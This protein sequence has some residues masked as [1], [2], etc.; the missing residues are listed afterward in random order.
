MKILYGEIDK[1]KIF[2][3]ITGDA[4]LPGQNKIQNIFHMFL[5]YLHTFLFQASLVLKL[6]H[7]KYSKS[8]NRLHKQIYE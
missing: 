5:Y 1:I 2:V 3:S 6:Q 4:Y 7:R 8:S